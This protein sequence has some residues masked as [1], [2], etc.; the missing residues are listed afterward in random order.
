MLGGNFFLPGIQ[1]AAPGLGVVLH[2]VPV[3]TLRDV[4]AGLTFIAKEPNPGLVVVPDQFI[5]ANRAILIGGAAQRRLP[6]I[7]GFRNMVSEGGLMSY[8]VDLV[9]IFRRSGEYIDRVFK[10]A[11]V[12]ELPIQAPVEFNLHS[13]ALLLSR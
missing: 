6:A 5:V 1:T 12:G 11:V 9:E 8:G 10:G 13:T 4:D 3:Y 7:Y 2:T